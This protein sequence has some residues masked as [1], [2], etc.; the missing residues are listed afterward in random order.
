MESLEVAA[1]PNGYELVN[2]VEM[3]LSRGDH[4]EIVNPWFKKYL[5]KDDFV[6]LRI[7]SDRFSA[8]LDAPAACMCE[9]CNEPTTKPILCHEHPATLV[10]IP[11]QAVPSRGWGEQFWVRILD[12]QGDLMRGVVDNVLY[13]TRL[14]GLARGD[15]VIFHEDHVLS[16]HGVHNREMLL[17]MSNEDFFDFGEWLA[18]NGEGSGLL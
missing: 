8:H 1:L 9:Q 16:V 18:E 5:D 14:H 4:F 6:E 13:E 3:H 7:D 12:R 2:G 10:A 15:E 11:D 17:R